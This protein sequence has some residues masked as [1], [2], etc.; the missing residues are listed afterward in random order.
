MKKTGKGAI[1]IK[2][3]LKGVKLNKLS[4]LMKLQKEMKEG[5]KFIINYFLIFFFYYLEKL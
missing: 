2:N 4:L 1:S 3:F 5:K